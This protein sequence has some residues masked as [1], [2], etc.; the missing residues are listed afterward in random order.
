MVWLSF[1]N[2]KLP[3]LLQSG[4]HHRIYLT[5]GV[6]P[7]EPVGGEDFLPPGVA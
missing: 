7:D 5:T 6:E 4:S 3:D 1:K 2:L